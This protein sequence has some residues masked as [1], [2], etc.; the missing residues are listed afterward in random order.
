MLLLFDKAKWVV[1]L[2]ISLWPVE[3]GDLLS[4]KVPPCSYGLRIGPPLDILS[5]TELKNLS[6]WYHDELVT[7]TATTRI[8]SRVC[9]RCCHWLWLWLSIVPYGLS[10][11]LLLHRPLLLFGNAKHFVP[12]EDTQHNLAVV[13]CNMVVTWWPNNG[14]VV[15]VVC[16]TDLLRSLLEPSLAWM[17]V[18]GAELS[19]RQWHEL[20][21]QLLTLLH[22]SFTSFHTSF[23][24]VELA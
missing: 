21:E 5:S 9:L 24:L 3:I 15:T 2:L 14:T 10:S 19:Q 11:S 6:S 13:V 20:S 23:A 4:S 7:R 17:F 18:K 22:E 12:F 1:S 8:L 16:I